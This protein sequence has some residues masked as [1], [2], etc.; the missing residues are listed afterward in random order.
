MSLRAFL[1]TSSRA[2]PGVCLP[3]APPGHRLRIG[4]AIR[5]GGWL[6][7]PKQT[8]P[9][10]PRGRPGPPRATSP[11]GRWPSRGPAL[12]GSLPPL[13]T[14]AVRRSE[15]ARTTSP[16]RCATPFGR[17]GWRTPTCSV[18][19]A[20]RARRPRRASWP[21][22][23]TARLPKTASQTAL[24]P[25]A[26]PFGPGRPWTS[27]SSTPRQTASWKKCG[28]CCPGWPSGTPGPLEGLHHRRSPPAHRRRR[29]RAAEDAGRAPQPRRVR[30]GHHTTRKRCCRLSFPAPS[31]SSS[32]SW[33]VAMLTDLLTEI[34]EDAGLAWRP[35]P[36]ASPY[37]EV[38]ARPATPSRHS[39]S[40][41]PP[42]ATKMT[43]RP[44]RRSGGGP[45]RRGMWGRPCRPWR[46]R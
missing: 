12:P 6:K 2:Q 18:A 41:P 16:G 44:D 26:P 28:T 30:T 43:S 27:S 38:V 1:R 35:P 8:K 13:P 24:A 45:G 21:W 9:C 40:W 31:T 20:A 42:A 11:T 4:A 36:S 29:Q 32:G 25:R 37:N 7:T 15:E 17:A 46:R 34:N 5:L 19:H 23:S 3:V 33:T 22:R 39:N 14:S 10:P